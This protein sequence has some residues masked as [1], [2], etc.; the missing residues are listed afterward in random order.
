M[1]LQIPDS[2]ATQSGCGPQDMLF[3]LAIG[4]FMDGRLTLGQAGS[5]L[6]LSKPQFMDLLGQRGI[7]MPY[8]VDDLESDLKTLD[9]LFPKQP[10][11]SA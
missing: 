6:G 3:G 4:L 10:A 5:A 7:P 11:M 9:K 8:D 1:T 2:L